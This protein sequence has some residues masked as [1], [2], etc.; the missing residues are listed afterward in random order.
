MDRMA[1]N[2]RYDKADSSPRFQKGLPAESSSDI[3]AHQDP[4]IVFTS[5]I[6]GGE[7]SDLFV[8]EIDI[9]RH[10]RPYA[11]RAEATSWLQSSA[12]ID[13][14]FCHRSEFIRCPPLYHKGDCKSSLS[15]NPGQFP[16]E[17]DLAVAHS[18]FTVRRNLHQR[19]DWGRFKPIKKRNSTICACFGSSPSRSFNAASRAPISIPLLS[20]IESGVGWGRPPRAFFAVE[21]RHN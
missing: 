10:E 4:L 21:R 18:R 14:S 12:R 7:N 8:Q 1:T 5:A 11:L 17:P 3:S 9:I 2:P 19:S 15:R 6:R 13:L 16:S 20:K